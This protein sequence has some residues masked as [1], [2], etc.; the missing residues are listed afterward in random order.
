GSETF[1][2]FL[3]RNFRKDGSVIRCRWYNSAQRDAAGNIVS[4]LSLVDDVSELHEALANL[5]AAREQAE[6][7]S[8]AKSEFLAN[9][10]HEIRTPLNGLLGMLQLLR[11]DQLQAQQREYVDLAIASGNRLTRLL[12]DILDISRI[13]AGKMPM[14]AAPFVLAEALHQVMEL[15]QPTARQAGVAFACHIDPRLPP[16]VI[17]DSCRLQQ[18]LTNLVGN[19]LKYTTQGHVTL[20]AQ[21]LTDARPGLQRVLFTVED[22]GCGIPEDMIGL[23]FEPFSQAAQ[24]FQRSHQGAGLGLSI[25]KRLVALMGGG[26]AVESVPDQGTSFFFSI[27]FALPRA[28]PD[29]SGT[30]GMSGQA[31]PPAGRRILVADDDAISRL[32]ASRMLEKDGEEVVVVNNGRQ[33]LEALRREPF[34][35]VLMDVQMP[36]LNGVDA[37][38]AIRRGEAGE[39]RRHT[40][41]IAMTAYAMPGDRE[42]FLAAGMDAYLAKPIEREA[43]TD[44]IND[45][46]RRR[47]VRTP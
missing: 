30:P 44:V 34:D 26:I 27:S 11:T 35:L 19:A 29:A 1:N 33:A 46:L 4:L 10:S 22:T 15:F 23:L 14:E 9:M 7:A 45:V 24:G 41:I 17:G 31:A 25:C 12:S 21:A 39:A 16:T 2:T 6:A 47:G 38:L 36:I 18:V 28:L 8:R 5:A 40:P 32:T 37:S 13:E 42:V 3:N 43:L 20:Y